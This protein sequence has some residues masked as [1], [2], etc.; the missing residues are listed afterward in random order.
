[1]IRLKFRFLLVCAICSQGFGSTTAVAQA[2]A[3]SSPS[4]S[5]KGDDNSFPGLRVVDLIAIN[6]D[7]RPLT[8]LKP[9][10]LRLFEDKA[11]Q[12]I[13]SFSP[14]ANQPL[15]I[16]LFFDVSGSR[17][18][19][20][21]VTD[22]TRLTSELVHTVWHDGV[23]AFLVSFSSDVI[24]LTQPTQKPEEIDRGLKQVPDDH[25]GSTSVYDALCSVRPEFLAET[26]GRKAYIVFSDFEDNS[27]RNKADCVLDVAHG[28]R[29]AIFPVVLSGD[30]TGEQS[31][32]AEKRGREQAQEFANETGGEVLIP[33]SP[34]QLTLVFQRLAADL[35]SAYRITYVSSSPISQDKRKRSKLRL[36]T[37]RAGVKLLCPKR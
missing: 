36:E 7:G 15:T 1:V 34:K 37:T 30:F 4:G 2:P 22:E 25:R 19:D 14:A 28:A 24:A 17:R 33:E 9:E 20:T 5:P 21:H 35:Q 6:K 16:G 23:T 11:E 10:E 3:V 27:S 18:A 12:K 8:D 32:K 26:P 29:V 13:K 31:K